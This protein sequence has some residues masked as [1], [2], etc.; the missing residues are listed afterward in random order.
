MLLFRWF[1]FNLVANSKFN[2][3]NKVSGELATPR[4]EGKRSKMWHEEAKEILSQDFLLTQFEYS[5][6]AYFS[7]TEFTRNMWNYKP[8]AYPPFPFIPC[9]FHFSGPSPSTSRPYSHT[10]SRVSSSK[11]FSN[12]DPSNLYPSKVRLAASRRCSSPSSRS[13]KLSCNY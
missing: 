11:A 1:P 4:V 13:S 9:P 3:A 12:Q 8:R 2:T 5:N 7:T 6:G 10:S